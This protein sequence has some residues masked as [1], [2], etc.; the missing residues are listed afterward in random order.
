MHGEIRGAWVGT[1]RARVYCPYNRDMSRTVVAQALALTT[2]P[3]AEIETDLLIV[4]LF[5]G[6]TPAGD[7]KGIDDG[8]GGAVGRAIAA[9]E[10]QGRPYEIFV[11]PF[12]EGWRTGRLLAIGVGKRVEF[13][14]ERLRRAATAGALWARQRRV[15][16]VAWLHRGDLDAAAS[17]QA[18]AEGL[19]L[20]AF[21]TDRYKSGERQGAAAEQLLV[22]VDGHSD[23]S[24]RLEAAVE[25]G[26]IL[27]DCS[28]IARDLC[29]E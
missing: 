6:D 16:R 28:N 20:A 11:T 17:V 29:N 1:G 7:L 15:A 18:A 8:T 9:A 21:G 2:T 14:T 26:R 13:T 3:A 25:R 23:D 4:P 12:G 22:A 10:L 24:R 27:G 5:E 19:V